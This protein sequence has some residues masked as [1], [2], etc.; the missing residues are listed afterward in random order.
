MSDPQNVVQQLINELVS[1][2]K[3]RGVQVAAFLDGQMIVNAWA[4]IADHVTKEPV[5]SGTLFPAFSTTKGIEA[6]LVHLLA[7]RGKF[8]YETPIS[9]IWPEFGRNGKDTITIRQ[10]LC[11]ASGIPQM[12]FGIGFEELVEWDTMCAAVADL[13]PLW[14]PG[15]RIEYHAMTFGW[16]LGEVLRRVDGRPFAQMMDEEIC[17]PL[18]ITTM[19]VG[20]PDVEA[21]RVARLEE[22]GVKAVDPDPSIPQPVPAWI[23][24]LH[25]MMNREDCR[26]ACIPASNGIMNALSVAR[27]YAALLPGGVD[28][29]ELLP[30]SRVRLASEPQRLEHPDSADYPKNWGLGYQ[31]GGEGSI[32]GNHVSAFGHCGYGGSLGF[33]DPEWNLAV[34]LT[35]NLFSESL[36]HRTIMTALL[37]SVGAIRE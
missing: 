17:R 6:T 37:E 20:I 22:Y 27:H 10:A 16:I 31:L 30:P 18:G 33:A 8:T 23:G 11:H 15:T 25:E 12:P 3:E 2:G 24:P 14:A 21:G 35:K 34:G 28:G 1:D 36:S 4:G 13:K 32:F 26:K 19:F 5:E 29:I 7:E 9:Q